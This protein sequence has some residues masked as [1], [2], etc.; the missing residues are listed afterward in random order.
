MATEYTEV[1]IKCWQCRGSGYRP[2]PGGSNLCPYCQGEGKLLYGH[3]DIT[4]LNTKLDALDTKMDTID[5]HLDTIET[6]IDA[7]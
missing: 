2:Y 3:L 1:Y 5:A 6:K 7:L 4:G